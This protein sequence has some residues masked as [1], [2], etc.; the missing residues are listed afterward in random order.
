MFTLLIMQEDAVVRTAAKCLTWTQQLCSARARTRPWSR[1]GAGSAEASTAPKLLAT[2]PEM[3]SN[4]HAA[5]DAPAD[6]CIHVLR[7]QCTVAN[8]PGLDTNGQHHVAGTCRCDCH[9]GDG[10]E[11]V[12]GKIESLMLQ[13]CRRQLQL[14][15]CFHLITSRSGTESMWRKAPC[16]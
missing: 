15:A 11:A 8:M 7:M 14:A 10:G 4:M 6:L 5:Q 1:T 2:S 16:R 13:G 12:C 9:D 3:D